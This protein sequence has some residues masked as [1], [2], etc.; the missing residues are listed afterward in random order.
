MRTQHPWSGSTGRDLLTSSH[1]SRLHAA[2][3]ATAT[4][5]SPCAC[6]RQPDVLLSPLLPLLLQQGVDVTN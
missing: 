3:T 1:R 5:H 6:G 4:P 2:A